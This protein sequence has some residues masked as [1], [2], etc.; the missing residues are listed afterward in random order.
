MATYL[1]RA[2]GYVFLISMEAETIPAVVAI[3]IAWTVSN[4]RD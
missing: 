3:S 2:F 4:L 1:W